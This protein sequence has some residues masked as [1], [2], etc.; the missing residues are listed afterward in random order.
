[1]AAAALATGRA[2]SPVTVRFPGGD[3]IV[4][5]ADNQVVLTGPA[6]EV[7]DGTVAL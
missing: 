7:F 2:A 3:L 4:E 6:V 1:M 5:V